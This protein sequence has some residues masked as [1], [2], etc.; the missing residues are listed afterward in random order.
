MLEDL[1]KDFDWELEMQKVSLTKRKQCRID[2]RQ[3]LKDLP[4]DCKEPSQITKQALDL[5][6]EKWHGRY[7]E[8]LYQRRKQS[9]TLFLSWLEKY[10][11]LPQ[12]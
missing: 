8:T 10:G 3:L 12:K 1:I 11:Y 2:L 5:I 7:S 9:V 4:E 6:D